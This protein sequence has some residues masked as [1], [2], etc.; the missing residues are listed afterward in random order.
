VAPVRT[1]KDKNILNTQ[2]YCEEREEME[3]NTKYQPLTHLL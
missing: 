1:L 2:E 3:I